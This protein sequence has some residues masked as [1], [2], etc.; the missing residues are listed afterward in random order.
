MIPSGYLGRDF[1]EAYFLGEA[2]T[3]DASRIVFGNSL[4]IECAQLYITD[5]LCLI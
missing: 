2:P 3:I 4:V 5:F 1:I